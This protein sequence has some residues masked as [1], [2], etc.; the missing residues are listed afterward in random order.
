MLLNSYYPELIGEPLRLEL[1][2]SLLLE[3]ITEFI[4]LGERKS[5]VA[6]HMIGIVG[7]KI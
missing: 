7:D 5:S 3:T 2:F 1:Y 6:V 4:V